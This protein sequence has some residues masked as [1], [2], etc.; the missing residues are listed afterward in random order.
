MAVTIVFEEDIT[1]P[2]VKPVNDATRRIMSDPICG[3]EKKGDLAGVRVYSFRVLDQK[4]LLAY[5]CDGQTFFLLSLGGPRELLSEPERSPVQHS[6]PQ[7]LGNSRP[8][9]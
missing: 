3:E 2:S 8:L 7:D 6:F 4:F 1:E 9:S 5:E